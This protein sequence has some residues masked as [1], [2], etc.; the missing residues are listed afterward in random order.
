MMAVV[1]NAK[2]TAKI[3]RMNLAKFDRSK[4][5]NEWDVPKN[6]SAVCFVILGYIDGEQPHS[7]PRKPNRIK[8]IE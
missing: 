2:L 4:L 5:L 6:Y 7:K 1:Q 8:I 3:S